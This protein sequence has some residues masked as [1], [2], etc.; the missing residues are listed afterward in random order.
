[1]L[2]VY[3]MSELNAKGLTIHTAFNTRTRYSTVSSKCSSSFWSRWRFCSLNI[4]GN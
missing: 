2:T 1:M 4:Q 3:N